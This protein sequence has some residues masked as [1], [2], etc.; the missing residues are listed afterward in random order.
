[1]EFT[2]LL[3]NEG[4]KA[5][6][7]GRG[8]V[9]D[10][11]FVERLWRS[12]KYEEVYLPTTTKRFRKPG[13]IWAAI[14]NFTMTSGRTRRWTIGRRTNSILGRRRRLRRLRRPWFDMDRIEIV[15]IRANGEVVFPGLPKKLTFGHRSG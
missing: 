14:F 5:S 8:R 7:D 4:I 2:G 15:V 12:V 1:V 11:I 6:M 3:L 9:Y 10:N 13:H